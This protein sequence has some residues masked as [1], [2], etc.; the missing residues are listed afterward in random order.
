MAV[1]WVERQR[2]E[3]PSCT[4][5]SLLGGRRG[6]GR[7]QLSRQRLQWATEV[8]GAV[9]DFSVSTQRHILLIG[10]GGEMN[11]G[12][13]WGQHSWGAGLMVQSELAW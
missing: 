4:P 6:E 5:R 1:G 9:G 2:E 8:S 11:W 7:G 3:G 13:P 10:A 12:G